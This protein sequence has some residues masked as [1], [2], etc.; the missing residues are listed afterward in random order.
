[1]VEFLNYLDNFEEKLNNL[2]KKIDKKINENKKI[3]KK[4]VKSFKIKPKTVNVNKPKI[5]EY[6]EHAV[7]ILDGLPDEVVIS[8]QQ[9][10]KNKQIIEH[11]LPSVKG[12]ATA[13]L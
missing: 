2:T 12:H 3:V 6:R 5:I 10:I 13:L 9:E 7:A 4:Q 11:N 1:M 8:E